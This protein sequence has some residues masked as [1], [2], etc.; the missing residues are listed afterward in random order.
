MLRTIMLSFALLAALPVMAGNGPGAVRKLAES[1]ML[2]TGKVVIGTDGMVQ[3][4]ELDQAA[5]V[6][7]PLAEFVGKSLAQWRFEPIK[8]DGE[9]V[10]ARVPM[11]IRLVANRAEDGNYSVRIASTHFGSE[12]ALVASDALQ[13]LTMSPPHYPQGALMAGGKGTVYLVVQV[14]RD[15]KVMNVDAEQ[16]NLRVVGSANKMTQLRKVLA[17]SAIRAARKWT[18][19]PPTTGEEAGKEHWLARVPVSYMFDG[20]KS[21]KPG[22]WETYIPGPRNLG[23]PWAQEQ[24]KLAGNPDALPGD[25]LYPLEEGAR[26]LTPP[27]G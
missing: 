26:L 19:T 8:V 27:A 1:S 12:K 5:S 15:G 10:R 4:H 24:L 7:P 6:T 17:D 23:M 11:S 18:F 16:V 22:E 3:S 13:K 21:A 25:G 20:E 14:G 9:V 2:V